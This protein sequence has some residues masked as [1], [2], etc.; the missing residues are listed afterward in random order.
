MRVLI[1]KM[2]SM[3]DVLHTLPAVTDAVEN[4]SGI[5][6]DWV[7]EE[8]FH[9]IPMWHRGVD[10]TIT[11]SLRK[12]RRE[13]ALWFGPEVRRT[14]RELRQ[15]SYDHVIDAQG[16]YK[17]AAIAC[18][19]R[20]RRA[21]YDPDSAREPLAARVYSKHTSTTDIA[22][23]IDRSRLL[24][25]GTL[26]YD[27]PGTRPDYGLSREDFPLARSQTPPYLVFNHAS[28]WTTKLWPETYWRDL[29]DRAASRDLKV[30]LP[31]GS[32]QERA[33]AERLA[34]GRDLAVVLPEMK[35]G[36]LAGVMSHAVA[37][38]SV[39]TG[40]GHLAAALGTPAVSLYG[41]TDP[42]RTGTVGDNQQHLRASFACSPC[43]NRR[44]TYTGTA[45]VTPAC[46]ST[47]SPDQVW[48]TLQRYI[49]RG[50]K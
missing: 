46:Y 23:A 27:L 25:A 12:W 17:S 9:E 10:R 15:Q 26:G 45:E 44:C 49:D 20:G 4:V 42:S 33:S 36:Q 8:A 24:F 1:I 41:A 38:V 11:M 3:G 31:W 22:H 19:S 39:D 16:L 47:V 37:A 18:L 7:V 43:M 50:Q 40:L 14:W 6:F 2:T 30:L 48:G 28:T 13:P 29:I 32:A 34:E 21:G 35:L 5:R